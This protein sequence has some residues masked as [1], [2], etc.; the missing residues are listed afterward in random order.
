MYGISN[1]QQQGGGGGGAASY[2]A[3]RASLT[4]ADW[5]EVAGATPYFIGENAMTWEVNENTEMPTKSQP[6]NIGLVAGNSYTI[7]VVADNVTYTST[8][9]AVG[10]AGG[11]VMI[12][13]E[14]SNANVFVYD[15]FD[16]STMSP[17]AEG[18]F[19]AVETAANSFVITNF[20]GEGFGTTI[21]ATISD[22]AIK[23]NSAVTMYTNTSE[24]IAV[25]E[26]TNGNVTLIALSVPETA[27]P[28]NLEIVG[29]DTEGLFELINGYVPEIPSV[30]SNYDD[31]SNIPI[32][33]QDLSES[34]FTPVKDTY[35]RHTGTTNS[36]YTNGVIYKCVDI[37]S[38]SRPLRL[39]EL[40]TIYDVQ[41]TIN[42]AVVPLLPAE[43]DITNESTNV[44]ITGS[45]SP[46]LF[47]VT[48]SGVSSY[49]F[50]RLYPMDDDTETWLNEH[51]LSSIITEE[52]G[53]FTFKVDTNTLPT[54]YS[55]KYVIENFM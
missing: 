17:T 24:K 2:K 10:R 42:E 40:S 33:N 41:M 21:Q 53:K 25:G 9:E 30:S 6:T 19:C 46:Y 12:V 55:M 7:T 39:F 23:V 1:S 43:K 3:I 35:Y 38:T 52:S 14:M 16:V 54:A 28:Y 37:G 13:F 29:T 20:E 44:S 8:G 50:V 15:K 48:D 51:T 26:K 32:I 49:K 11:V 18:S 22:S 27:I 45:A 34:G 36:D 5:Q 4:Y 31:F 47:T